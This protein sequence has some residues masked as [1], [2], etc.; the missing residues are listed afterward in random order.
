MRRKAGAG[1]GG[2]GGEQAT[3]AQACSALTKGGGSWGQD[4]TPTLDMMSSSSLRAL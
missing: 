3:G 1:E 2:G 4:G